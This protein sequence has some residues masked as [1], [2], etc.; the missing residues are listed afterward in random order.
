[1]KIERA[2]RLIGSYN[3]TKT[4]IDDPFQPEWLKQKSL[5]ELDAVKQANRS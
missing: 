3:A 1:M 4:D 2:K 5:M